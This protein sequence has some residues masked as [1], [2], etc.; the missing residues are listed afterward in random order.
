MQKRKHKSILVLDDKA[1]Q[2]I[3][4]IKDFP[5]ERSNRCAWI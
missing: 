5:N 2:H 4:K 1:G 3:L